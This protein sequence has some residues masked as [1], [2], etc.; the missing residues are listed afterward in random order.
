MTTAVCSRMVH[1]AAP[2]GG[3]A[4]CP[5]CKGR[6]CLAKSSATGERCRRNPSV[7][8]TV[9][10]AHGARAP[11]VARKAQERQEQSRAEV[12]ARKL[13]ALGDAPGV[14]YR[15]ALLQEL[16][17]WHG[18]CNWYR[19]QI[20]TL[21]SLV[22]GDSVHYFLRLHDDAS[23]HLLRVIKACHDIRIDQQMMDVARTHADQLDQLLHAVL[24][25]LGHDPQDPTVR[26]VVRTALTLIGGAANNPPGRP[27]TTP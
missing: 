19:E 21:P 13:L 7:G 12:Q 14:D 3:R 25:G 24:N 10:A 23:D 1:L 22:Q 2:H 5:I 17:V 4:S 11:Q 6:R 27:V 16:A 18:V 9:C 20:Q 26:Q 8:A 15:E